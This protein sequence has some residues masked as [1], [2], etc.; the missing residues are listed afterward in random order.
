MTFKVIGLSSA[1]FQH[2][3]GLSDEE[4]AEHGVER[5]IA[6]KKHAFP[7][8]IELRDAERTAGCSPI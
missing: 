7:D 8:R 3:F 6:D 4:L 2:L 5:H 1:P